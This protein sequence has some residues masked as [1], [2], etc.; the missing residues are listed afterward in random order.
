MKPRDELAPWG[1]M[2]FMPRRYKVGEPLCKRTLVPLHVCP[3]LD[4]ENSNPTRIIS[5]L[6]VATPDEGV[7]SAPEKN[8]PLSL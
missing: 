5:I 8:E 3:F 1:F 6:F 7:G 4:P 2:I